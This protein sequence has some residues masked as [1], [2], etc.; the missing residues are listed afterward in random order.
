MVWQDIVA[1]A[2][3]LIFAYSLA[4][5]VYREYK[6]KKDLV[7]ARTAFFMALGTYALSVVYFSYSLPYATILSTFCATMWLAMFL[8]RIFYKK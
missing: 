4:Y 3:N 2:A 1:S 7:T 8:I 6:L 5:Q